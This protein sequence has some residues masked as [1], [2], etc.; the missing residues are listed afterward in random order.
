LQSKIRYL[1]IYNKLTTETDF[2]SVYELFNPLT[3]IAKSHFWDWF[4]GSDL[5]NR[6]IKHSGASPTYAMGDGVDAG[7]QISTGTTNNDRGGIHMSTTRHY[8]Q[9]NSIFIAVVRSAV[10]ITSQ[11]QFAG[12]SAVDDPALANDSLAVWHSFRQ[13]TNFALRTANSG[14][15]NSDTEGSVA[16]DTNLHSVKVVCGDTP[17]V[18]LF[19]DGVLDVTK[20]TTLPNSKMQPYFSTRNNGG[21]AVS[22]LNI[23]YCETFNT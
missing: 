14:E 7:F 2:P 11:Q 9:E 19:M 13:L 18:K 12:F 23:I 1:E 17:D 6:W 4:D 22:E 10:A 5:N 16:L 21:T 8:D 15:G 3:T 20:T